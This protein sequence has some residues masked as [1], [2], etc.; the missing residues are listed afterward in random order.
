M[1]LQRRFLLG[2]AARAGSPPHLNCGDEIRDNRYTKHAKGENHPKLRL[3]H[4]MFSVSSPHRKKN[5]ISHDL[6]H[7]FAN[8]F[9]VQK[10]GCLREV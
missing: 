8:A 1:I 3:K 4:P 9:S 5:N 10:H 2:P 7:R 6:S